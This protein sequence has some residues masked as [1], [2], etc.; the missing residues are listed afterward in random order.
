MLEFNFYYIFEH[1]KIIYVQ[2]IMA[3]IIYSFTKLTIID[4]SNG[5]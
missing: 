2:K 4:G 1:L 5:L 3:V